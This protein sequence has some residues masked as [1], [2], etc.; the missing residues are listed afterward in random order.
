MLKFKT[1]HKKFLK[2]IEAPM[3]ACAGACNDK[4]S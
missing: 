1:A 3:P 4:E 2:Y